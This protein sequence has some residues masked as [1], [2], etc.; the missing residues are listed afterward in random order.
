MS[1]LRL[2]AALVLLETILQIEVV[3]SLPMPGYVNK[4]SDDCI[5][6]SRWASCCDIQLNITGTGTNATNLTN[7]VY[8]LDHYGPF[9]TTYGYCDL[10]TDG[11]G[12]L[13]I[14]RR[15][16]S[17]NFQQRLQKYEDGFG[18]LEEG[19][20][21]WYGL[22]ALSHLTNRSVWELRVDLVNP[23]SKVHAHYTN[24][25]IGDTSEGYKLTLGPHV[26]DKSTAS[27][28]LQ[29]YNGNMFYAW[30]NDGPEVDDDCA[31]LAGGGWWYTSGECGGQRGG[32][33]TAAH[34]HLKGWYSEETEEKIVYDLIE[35]KIRQ[36]N[37]F[38]K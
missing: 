19:H 12:W 7:G 9:S 27:D 29:Q 8:S 3:S 32:I 25:S 26:E 6:S 36:T 35:M 23:D 2:L 21:F 5:F 13:V 28:S 37:C 22:K 10:E 24:F 20:T 17:F 15:Q 14:F 1:S 18:T 30:D 4:T 33:L 11:G 34:E 31:D 16:G 38:T